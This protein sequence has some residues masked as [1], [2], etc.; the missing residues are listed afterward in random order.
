[1]HVQSGCQTG[2]AG[3]TRPAASEGHATDLSFGSRS[4]STAEQGVNVNIIGTHGSYL[5]K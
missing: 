3:L 2:A 1:M 5:A 4:L